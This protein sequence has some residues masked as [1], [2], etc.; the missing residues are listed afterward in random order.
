MD[1]P[2]PSCARTPFPGP[3]LSHHHAHLPG[4]PTVIAGSLGRRAPPSPFIVV[5]VVDLLLLLVLLLLGV[6]SSSPPWIP[7]LPRHPSPPR[8]P[9]PPPHLLALVLLVSLA[10]ASRLPCLQLHSLPRL[11]LERFLLSLLKGAGQWRA[12]RAVPPASAP[13]FRP[14]S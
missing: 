1:C 6:S 2:L 3:I 12:P 7:P 5:V 8:P 4:L 13:R 14:L 10:P 11:C 9:L